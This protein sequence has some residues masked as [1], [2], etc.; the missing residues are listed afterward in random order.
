MLRDEEL[1]TEA[2]GEAIAYER[3]DDERKF[4]IASGGGLFGRR[5]IVDRPIGTGR[6]RRFQHQR[7]VEEMAGDVQRRRNEPVPRREPVV[8][9]RQRS[10]GL[11]VRREHRPAVPV[12]RAP[13][14]QLDEQLGP[15]TDAVDPLVRADP[16]REV[17][18]V[19]RLVRYDCGRN[20]AR[21]ERANDAESVDIASN[22]DD[23]PPVHS[24]TSVEQWLEEHDSRTRSGRFVA[25]PTSSNSARRA[26]CCAGAGE[27]RSPTSK[28]SCSLSDTRAAVTASSAPA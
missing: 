27:R 1:R 4:K 2:R 20:S 28:R 22:Y 18:D 23:A 6:G 19:E 16:P 10:E 7:L 26:P 12:D 21:G 8:I 17:G 13:F 24:G 14:E 5:P 15:F 25:P 11:V 3:L 9:G